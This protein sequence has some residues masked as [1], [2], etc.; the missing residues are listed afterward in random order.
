MWRFDEDD[1]KYITKA[2]ELSNFEALQE[3]ISKLIRKNETAKE[4]L[5]LPRLR[6]IFFKIRP[7]GQLYWFVWATQL[8]TDKTLSIYKQERDKLYEMLPTIA[9]IL[10]KNPNVSVCDLFD[11]ISSLE[12]HKM[13][14]GNPVA[15]EIFNIVTPHLLEKL[16]DAVSKCQMPTLAFIRQI[17][18]IIQ[19]HRKT[20]IDY[21][22]EADYWN[23]RTSLEIQFR[24]NSSFVS[25][26]GLGEIY[27][28][29]DHYKKRDKPTMFASHFDHLLFLKTIDHPESYLKIG[30]LMIADLQANTSERSQIIKASGNN[31]VR[32]ILCKALP[33][34]LCFY[35][36]LA[37]E[38]IRQLKDQTATAKYNDEHRNMAHFYY[39]I[40]SVLLDN[41]D[42]K[43]DVVFFK[44]KD[45][46]LT[47][48]FALELCKNQNFVISN[49]TKCRVLQDLVQSNPTSQILI[50]AHSLLAQLSNVATVKPQ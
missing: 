50:E 16:Y 5:F 22:H 49:S 36:K 25:R 26:P 14:S 34:K 41:N 40:A 4:M 12:K 28:A 18:V 43:A 6:D 19:S 38:R 23:D 17:I 11:F 44:G 46:S 48:P 7:E 32:A 35:Q 24:T 13:I 3:V 1:E 27:C 20:P 33:D 47:A 42:A 10:K 21:C 30:E 31:L 9:A 37:F 8:M 39:T 45:H 15:F 2:I 29:A